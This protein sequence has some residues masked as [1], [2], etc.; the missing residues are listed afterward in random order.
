MQV[1]LTKAG[2]PREEVVINKEGGVTVA[3]VV[4]NASANFGIEGFSVFVNGTEAD[5]STP[6]ADGARIS[7]SQA[8]KGNS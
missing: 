1:T 6:V 4:A 3:D 5:P 7:I 8:A 2:N